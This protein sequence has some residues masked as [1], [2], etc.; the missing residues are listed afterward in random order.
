VA[1][2][3]RMP[4]IELSGLLSGQWLHAAGSSLLG[5][6]GAG[7]SAPLFDGGRGAAEVDAASARLRASE[8]VLRTAVRTAVQ[9]VENALAAIA[10]AVERTSTTK[11]SVD[12]AQR[13]LLA[14]EAQWRAGAVSLFEL[15]DARRQLAAAQDGAIA[16]ARDS[17][18]AWIALVRASGN[19]AMTLE[20]I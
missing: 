7:L 19:H 12:A 16:A 13:T 14:T 20:S 18:Q 6:L 15:E 2:A 9:D 11:V 17:G 10:S 1:R 4:R 3:E 5:S 8:A